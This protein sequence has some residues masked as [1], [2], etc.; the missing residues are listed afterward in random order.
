PHSLKVSPTHASF[1]A[2]I[3]TDSSACTRYGY[4][5]ANGECR[6]WLFTG[7]FL[8]EADLLSPAYSRTEISVQSEQND[9]TGEATRRHCHGG[10]AGELA[11]GGV[12]FNSLYFPF[13]N[14]GEYGQAT[15]EYLYWDCK[16]NEQ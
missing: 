16:A 1:S 9:R 2:T 15:G 3:D 7:T 14:P 8:L 11:A 12:A 4:E 5:C 6:E 13:G 10:R